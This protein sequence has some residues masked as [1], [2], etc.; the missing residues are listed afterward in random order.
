MNEQKIDT[1]EVVRTS[2]DEL[3][4]YIPA[5]WFT[6]YD[7]NTKYDAI[8]HLSDNLQL[9]ENTKMNEQEIDSTIKVDKAQYAHD[10]IVD[11][12]HA[13]IARPNDMGEYIPEDTVVYLITQIKC[14]ITELG[15]TNQQACDMIDGCF[16]AADV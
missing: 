6:K 14:V 3:L 4:S 5:E 12:L 13:F 10:I 9:D 15:Y 11:N 2:Y 16:N 1:F 7:F 8:Q